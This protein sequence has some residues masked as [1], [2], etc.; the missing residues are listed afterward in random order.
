MDAL[1][2][3][4]AP[5][6]SDDDPDKDQHPPLK[7]YKPSLPPAPSL[8]H[9]PPASSPGVPGRYVSKRERAAMAATSLAQPAAAPLQPL[10]ELPSVLNAKLPH[11]IQRKLDH[12]RENAGA[13]NR[14]PQEQTMK[15]EGHSKAVIAVRWSPTH[16]ALL[17]SGGMDGKAYVWNV[18]ES[19]GN[20]MARCLSC[21]NHALKDVQWSLDGTSVLSCGFDQ[22]ARLSNVETGAQTQVFSENQVVNVVRFHP[23]EENLFIT[24]GSKGSVKLWDIRL[25]SSVCEYSKSLGQVMDVDFSPD[26][27]RFITTSDIAKRNSSDKSLVVWNF[28]TQIPLSNQVY[29]EAY[30]CPSVRFHPFEQC[31]IAQSNADYIA[32]FSG[33]TPFK[34]NKVKRFKSHQV[35]GYRIQCNFSPDGESVI[36]GSADG[37]VYFYNYRSAQLIKK[38]ASHK[39]VCSDVVYH[40]FLPSVVATCGWD[41]VVSIFE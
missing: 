26:G 13:R 17:A 31:F 20:Q 32:V 24:G 41:G 2:H 16:G 10:P 27:S 34:L 14:C 5:T 9:L 6:L 25:G 40:P 3:A 1:L 15:L 38:Y 21:H 37:Y 35:A 33:R 19:P 11:H 8:P 18:W 22:T 39:G 7:R 30:T 36:T 12:A 4:Y 23:S 29:L 28:A